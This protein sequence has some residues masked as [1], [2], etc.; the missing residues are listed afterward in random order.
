MERHLWA[1]AKQAKWII[2][3]FLGGSIFL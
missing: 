2:G 3:G 1:N